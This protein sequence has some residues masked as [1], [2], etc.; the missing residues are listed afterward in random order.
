MANPRWLTYARSLMGTREIVGPKHSAVIMGWIKRLGTKVLGVVVKDDET[1]W[2]GTFMAEVM[3]KAGLTPPQ[4]A[5]RA[6]S[7]AAWGTNISAPRLGAVLVFTRSGG[8]HVGIYVGERSDAYRVLGGNQGNAVSETWIAKN[9]LA[10]N[11][12]R[13]PSS[14]PLPPATRVM[15]KNDG[16]PLSSNEV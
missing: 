1:P 8:G 3:S 7:W 13:W 5:V 11:G 4:V 9:R 12:I 6:S 10:R 15:L 2:C 14:E 16:A